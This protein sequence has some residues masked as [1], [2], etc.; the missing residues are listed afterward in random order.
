MRILYITNYIKIQQA[1]GYINDYMNDLLFYGLYELQQEGIITEL[2]DSTSIA[3]LYKYNDLFISKQALWGKGFSQTFLIEGDGQDV[4]RQNIV[5][6]IVNQYFDVIIYGAWNRCQD[7]RDV[8]EESFNG[9]VIVVDGADDTLIRPKPSRWIGFKREL[10]P[11]VEGQLPISFA[12]PEFKFSQPNYKKTKDYGTVIPGDNSTYIFT[13]EASYYKDY[14]DSFYG[15]TTKKG[16]Y[17]CIRHY[18]I[19][20]S[21]CMPYIPDIDSF[22]DT[23]LT[24]YP[25]K[26]IK[27]AMSLPDKDF[28][29]NM[30]YQL[31]DEVYQYAKENL[32]TKALAKYVLSK[33]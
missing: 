5:S 18:E 21:Y 3:H 14:N 11:G 22:P 12:I 19:P 28:D 10:M 6:K 17:D 8:V 25:K 33:I 30:Y 29:N 2:V 23:V 4:N 32:T 9:K 16:G 24:N 27:I 7:Y 15:V 26:L 1:G 31:M 20:A 13:D